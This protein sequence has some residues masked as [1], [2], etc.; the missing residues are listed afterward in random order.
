LGKALVDLA[1][2]IAK[3]EISPSVGCRFVM[4]DSKRNA[5]PFYEKCGFTILDTPANRDRVEPV[6]FVD[7]KKVD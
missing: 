2:G 5:A 7:L 4:V 3:R 6:M 1:L